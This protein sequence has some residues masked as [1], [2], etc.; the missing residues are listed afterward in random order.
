MLSQQTSQTPTRTAAL[1]ARYDTAWALWAPKGREGFRDCPEQKNKVRTLFASGCHYKQEGCLFSALG[2]WQPQTREIPRSVQ[3]RWVSLPGSGTGAVT[4][5]AHSAGQPGWCGWEQH[6]Q[7]Q[8]PL[9]LRIP[10]R[11]D[12]FRAVPARNHLT[13][14]NRTSLP[15]QSKPRLCQRSALTLTD[16]QGHCQR[17]DFE[18]CYY[19]W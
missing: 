13:R 16:S 17:E 2:W 3:R 18:R 9:G 6:R 4:P 12:I 1:P 7:L 15:G 11:H 10:Y 8:L 5:C 14:A 19:F